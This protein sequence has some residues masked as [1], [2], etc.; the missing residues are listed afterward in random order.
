M[1]FKYLERGQAPFLAF[2]RCQGGLLAARCATRFRPRLRGGDS[3]WYL[4]L[5]AAPYVRDYPERGTKAL[6]QSYGEGQFM[7][8]KAISC[9]KK[10]CFFF[11]FA[12][13]IYLA[14]ARFYTFPTVSRARDIADG[15]FCFI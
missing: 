7:M 1:N 11:A 10:Q 3:V 9:P 14:D 2:P 4:A 6:L 15:L 13:Y 8:A 5:C 12:Q